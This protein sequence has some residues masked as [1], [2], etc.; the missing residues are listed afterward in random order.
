MPI[1]YTVKQIVCKIFEKYFVDAI[2]PMLACVL[3]SIN[4]F[5]HTVTLYIFQTINCLQSSYI[6][7]AL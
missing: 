6:S 7:L 5:V 2:Y 1:K 4:I 3:W